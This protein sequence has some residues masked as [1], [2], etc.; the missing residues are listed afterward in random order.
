M[1][2]VAVTSWIPEPFIVQENVR[3]TDDVVTL[4]LVP[5]GSSGSGHAD[6]SV[7]QG[8]PGQFNMLYAHGIGEVPISISGFARDGALMHTIR[9]VGAVSKALCAMRHGSEVG[10][11]GPFGVG[12][13][14]E[15][16]D[17]MDVFVV[18]GGLGLAPLRPLI[19][20]LAEN[21]ERYGT[22]GVFYGGRS[23]AALLFEAERS[24][25]KT[26]HDIECHA[27]VDHAGPGWTGHVGVV[28]DLLPN[29]LARP[30]ATAAFVCGP[31]IMMRFVASDLKKRGV[32]AANVYLS[33]ERN[34]KCALGLCGRCQFSPHFICKDGPVFPL[35]KIETLL[36]VAEL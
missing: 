12:W 35:S 20:V 18:A 26:V 14:L 7:N 29:E 9:D 25:W 4:K 5:R 34:M 36:T 24:E 28:T 13:P 30:K 8:T 31:E 10:L 17:G 2:G 23:P 1:G 3:E 21:R 32:P 27:T 22:V 16:L 19:R 6:P 15:T 11:R 33:L